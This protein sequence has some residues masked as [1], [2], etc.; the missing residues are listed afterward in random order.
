MIDWTGFTWEAFATLVTG[1]GAL[2]AAVIVG[3]RQVAIQREQV[4]VAARQTNILDRQTALAEITLRNE[5]FEKRHSV[6]AATNDLLVKAIQNGGWVDYNDPIQN[7][8]LVA[9]DKAKF[10][11]RPSVSVDLQEIW[12]KVCEGT[13]IHREMTALYQ[14]EGHYG[15]EFP[16][17]SYDVSIWIGERLGNLS[18]VFG[19]ELKLSDH[20]MQLG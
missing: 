10:L 6:Y 15:Q 7:P 8:F 9:K 16:K 18:E 14:Q 2:V 3:L 19:H 20:D 5:L 12:E 11:F 1:I 13:A 4:A 17:R